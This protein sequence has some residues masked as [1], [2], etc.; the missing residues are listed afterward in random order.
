[1]FSG[2]KMLQ[3][4]ANT[5]AFVIKTGYQTTKGALIRDI[6]YPKEFEF[7]FLKDS[8]YLVAIMLVVITLVYCVTLPKLIEYGFSNTE[9]TFLTLDLLTIAVP[10]SLPAILSSCLLFSIHRLNKKKIFCISPQR[11]TLCGR[12]KTVVFD[13]TGTLTEDNLR[14]K[15]HITEGEEEEMIEAMSICHA[16][17]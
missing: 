10:P 4:K 6:L 17:A 1:M 12:I 7:K 5:R 2:S 8:L 11:I 3:V 15:D 16:I 13:K 9:I 14:I